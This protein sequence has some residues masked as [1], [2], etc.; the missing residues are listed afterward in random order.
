MPYNKCEEAT[1]KTFCKRSTT[2]PANTT[3]HKFVSMQDH[4]K[5][6]RL[7]ASR[8]GQCLTPASPPLIPGEVRPS[9]FLSRGSSAKLFSPIPLAGNSSAASQAD[10]SVGPLWAPFQTLQQ[11]CLIA[12][13]FWLMQVAHL[14]RQVTLSLETRNF[15][16]ARALTWNLPQERIVQQIVSKKLQLRH[17]KTVGVH[18]CL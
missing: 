16:D 13:C 7:A 1:T 12:G 9:R 18:L 15:L 11:E 14:S 5:P 8:T 4:L 17:T 3:P 10:L 2:L 6:S